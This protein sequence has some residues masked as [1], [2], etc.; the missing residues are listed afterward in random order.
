[1]SDWM[2]RLRRHYERA[3]ESYPDHELL[4]MFD[5][6]GTIVDLSRMVLH[7]LRAYDDRYGTNHFDG[8]ELEDVEV[9]ENQVD[10]L[11]RVGDLPADERERV[12]RWYLARR[13]QPEAIFASHRPFEGVMEVIRWFQLQPRTTVA[14]NTG[15]PESLRAETRFLMNAIGEEW[16]VEFPDELLFMNDGG[17]EEDVVHSKVAGVRHFQRL[18]YHVCAFVDN[19]PS[20]LEAVAAAE[21][22]DKVLLLHADTLF[23]SRRER[24]PG[25]S[26]SGRHWR[27]AP[28]ATEERLPRHIRYTWQAVDDRR[29]LR[30]FLNSRVRWAELDVRLDAGGPVP[31]VRAEPLAARR[32][33]RGERMMTLPEM[34]RVVYGRGRSAKLHLHGTDRLVEQV[35]EVTQNVGVASDEI[36][37]RVDPAAAGEETVRRLARVFPLAWLEAPAGDTADGLVHRPQEA[38]ERLERWRAAGI[39]TLSFPHDLPFL[40]SMVE[41]IRELGFGVDVQ[42]ARDVETFLRTVLLLPDSVTA[43]FG[44]AGWTE[45]ARAGA[46]AA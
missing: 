15:R 28:L 29:S 38:R 32:A 25:G 2:H 17:W 5:I 21:G 3:L 45:E 18:G 11:P 14:L 13:W 20:N 16:R 42:G 1:M 30:R 23:E 8:L 40:G 36:A 9:H 26:V 10:R 43:R 35:I 27:V 6:D 34:L 33:E 4:V 24:L 7:V 37:F 44:T 22:T 39:R 46:S 19:E 12:R 41:Q 31:V